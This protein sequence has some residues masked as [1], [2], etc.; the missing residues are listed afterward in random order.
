MM[1]RPHSYNLDYKTQWVRNKGTGN[2]GMDSRFKYDKIEEE[3][4]Q[5]SPGPTTA[6]DIALPK[7]IN[8]KR[9]SL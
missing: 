9:G 6:N 8:S 4:A 7:I 5:R 2:F 3:L 1:Y